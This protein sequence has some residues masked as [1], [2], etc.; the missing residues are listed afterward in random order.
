MSLAAG[1]RLG[2]YEI[3][4]PIGAGGMGEVY[5]ARDLKLGRQV[6][7]KVLPPGVSAD[8]DRRARFEQEAYAASALNHPNIVT[9]YDMGSAEGALYVAM[10]LVEGTTVRALLEAGP[11][12]PEKLLDVAVQ[13]ADGLASAHAAGI[14]H[15]D[16]KPDN[17]ILS[18]DG[19][20]KILDFGL[21][22]L[23]A[24][25]D[26]SDLPTL[27]P[28]ATQPG[29]ILGTAGYMSPE[30]ASG[31]SLDFRSDQFSLG[32][33][34]YEMASGKRAFRRNTTA[35][36]LTAIIREEPEPLGH[37]NPK[38]PA[39]LSWIIDRCLAKDPPERYASTLDLARELRTLREHLS[40][41]PVSSAAAAASPRNLPQRRTVVAA[42]LLVV[43][44]AL[45][46]WTLVQRGRARWA[47]ETALPEISRLAQAERYVDAMRLAR[48]AAT[49]I[50][51][52]PVLAKLWP[53][54]SRPASIETTPPGAEV[55]VKDYRYLDTEWQYL[56]R[57]PLADIKVPRGLLRCQLK[58]P[59]FRTVNMAAG[60]GNR[61][62]PSLPLLQIRV[63]LDEESKLP[64]EMVRIPGGKFG[65]TIPGLDHLDPVTVGDY[66]MDRC[67]VTNKEFRRFV[68]AGGYRER[69]YW[70]QPFVKDG[71]TISWEEAMAEFRDRMGRPGPATW[72]L[73]AYPQGQGE[74]PVAGVSWYE[75]AAYAEFVG[76]SL[77]TIYHWNH[78]ASPW[79]TSWIVPLSNVGGTGLV[80]VG[81]QQGL[82]SYGPFDMAGNVKEWCEN[83]TS[84][85]KRYLLGGA[86]NEL[87]YMF[88][89][90]DARSPWERS[91]THGFRCMRSFAA[92]PVDQT[93][94]A[95][96]EWP[97]RDFSKEK[98]VPDSVFGIYKAM[99]SYDKTSLAA[100]VESIDDQEEHWRKEKVTF[101]AA[102]GGERV[103]AYLFLPRG[104]APPYQTVLFF[105][106]SNAIQTRSSESLGTVYID[107]VI[108]SGRAV[109]YP[110]Y[111]STYERGDELT[112]DVATGTRLYRDHVL[113]WSKDL[114][115]SIDYLETRGDIDTRKVAYYGLSWGAALGA[116]LPAVEERIRVCVLFAGGIRLREAPARG[117]RDQLRPAR[118]GPDAD[119]EWPI[120]LLL[121]SGDV[122][123]A[124]VPAPGG[125]G[126]G[127]AP[128]RLR[129]GTR[130]ASGPHEQ[131]SP[132]LA[133]SLPGRGEVT[134][135]TT[136]Q[137]PE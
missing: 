40:E 136:R 95:P 11:V 15:R 52:D 86:W 127:Q 131:G 35:E 14:V 93:I 135:A 39:Q 20:V 102:Y 41:A 105:P 129:G 48:K 9:V 87:P 17:L 57:A 26:V 89:D 92:G 119:A 5:R 98:P 114:G 109:M 78:A 63:S 84:G 132:R 126:R 82:S 125:A 108:R 81:S 94:A 134:G 6:A 54:I 66:L 30:Q 80:A 23:A 55:Y 49:Y 43:L 44:A 8:P 73:G 3:L 112:S 62:L 51:S 27:A 100:V 19:F 25:A 2:H 56:G 106:G 61:S 124:D 47:R 116:I 58:K 31:K 91:P 90:P 18:R 13:V 28:H 97:V 53:D 7:V 68:D 45:G 137:E 4:A 121:R 99:Y 37:L 42:A 111:K 123:G 101:N 88:V 85:G 64:S 65:L 46:A 96:I 104:V 59:G 10:E 117:R 34:L 115:R 74:H 67:E 33:V 16:L 110:I 79:W 22:K 76:K 120:R 75:A 24:S 12:P 1:T 29:T 83:A 38:A 130:R 60:G 118:Q 21:A 72:E 133:G 122:A 77:P 70:K 50:P 32:A 107:F 113:Q 103:I 128:R 36:T 71:R 69:K